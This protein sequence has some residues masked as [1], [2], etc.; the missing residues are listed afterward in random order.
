MLERFTKGV[1]LFGIFVSNYDGA[2]AEAMLEGIHTGA[3]L[4]R[5]G[6]RAGAA[7]SIHAVGFEF[8]L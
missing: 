3:L 1:K 7:L 4:A 5:R 2:A 8:A 6:F